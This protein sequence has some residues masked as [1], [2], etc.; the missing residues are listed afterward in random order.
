M[1]TKLFFMAAIAACTATL[2]PTVAK[3]DTVDARC[4]VYP[5]GDDHATAVTACTFSQRQGA[6]GI[7]LADGTR[8]NLRPVGDD[9]GNYVDQNGDRAYRQA[10]LGN[11]GQIYRL[12]DESI[13]VYWDTAGLRHTE[14]N[15][16]IP[17]TYTTFVDPNHLIVQI[18]DAQFFFH[19]TLTKMYN[20]DYSGSD[21]HVRVILTPETGRV[22]IF[23]ERTGE[24]AYEYN[25]NPV[26][27]GE[28]P[29][30]MCDPSVEPC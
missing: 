13:Y 9:P 4:D 12:A 25:I 29:A 19:E 15:S 21:G 5:R 16:G 10:G 17:T 24:V 23:Y 1:Q 11:L 28:D 7:E 8:Y 26:Y 20:A 22:V 3:A 27:F 2:W 18:S 14:D 6:V 30:T